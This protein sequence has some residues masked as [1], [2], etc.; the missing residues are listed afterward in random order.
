[1]GGVG[2]STVAVNLA[3]TLA[4]MGATVCIF[5]ADNPVKKTII[6]TEY[7]GVKLV[8]FGFSEQGRAIMRGPM[9]S[10]VIDQ[11]LTATE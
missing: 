1:M 3:Y 7:L 2:K 9:V 5:D 6:S 10:G 11:L 8:S 4:G